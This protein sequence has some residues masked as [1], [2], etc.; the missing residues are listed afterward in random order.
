M[1]DIFQN[2]SEVWARA[3]V[4]RRAVLIVLLLACIGAAVVG[5]LTVS[6]TEL[7]T[8]TNLVKND[9]AIGLVFPALFSLAVI[10]ISLF[11]RNV[12]LDQ[13]VVF[14]GD[15]VFAPFDR[16]VIFDCDPQ[17]WRGIAAFDIC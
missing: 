15:L 8:K 1:A 17:C 13:H 6:L 7:L 2:L 11:A 10:L 9:A 4:F 5:V 16:A 12:H 14:Q 3:G